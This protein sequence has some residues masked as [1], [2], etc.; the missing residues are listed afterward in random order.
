MRGSS[1]A[2]LGITCILVLSSAVHVKGGSFILGEKGVPIQFPALPSEPISV[3]SP[4]MEIKREP[5]PLIRDIMPQE[6]TLPKTRRNLKIDAWLSVDDNIALA[7][8]DNRLK[9]ILQCTRNL[10]QHHIAY[11]AS[12]VIKVR[13]NKEPW[14]DIAIH[15]TK[16]ILSLELSGVVGCTGYEAPSGSTV[17]P[18]DQFIKEYKRD[19][20]RR[21]IADISRTLIRTVAL[22]HHCGITHNDIR[23]ENI[24]VS[25]D[26]PDVS[27]DVWLVGF[28]KAIVD[29]VNG[30]PP[31]LEGAAFRRLPPEAY[32]HN[33]YLDDAW[34]T[35]L[36]VYE[37]FNGK[38]PYDTKQVRKP[39]EYES[40]RGKELKAYYKNDG[41]KL[42]LG[43]FNAGPERIDARFASAVNKLL[44]PRPENRYLPEQ[45][46]NMLPM[47]SLKEKSWSKTIKNFANGV[48]GKA[49]AF[50]KA[51]V[52]QFRAKHTE[53]SEKQ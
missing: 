4:N 29:D 40:M 48:G 49:Q 6:L 14:Q 26:R 46:M 35:G 38:L 30:M 15:S 1:L 8:Y 10:T 24:L 11:V 47:I 33:N 34:A 51:Q 36:V 12:E 22:L 52:K 44:E 53:L 28:Y 31:A 17:K 3:R 41:V 2:F 5:L 21:V 43:F 16:R 25:Q 20:A 19:N 27:P 18:L 39:Q 50:A 7:T 9:M 32:L 13:A 45:V 42:S 23:S 37:M